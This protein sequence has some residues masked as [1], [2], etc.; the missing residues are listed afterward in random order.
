LRPVAE[1][2]GAN[3][4]VSRFVYGSRANVPDYMVKG[5][6][7]YRIVTDQLGSPRLVVDVVTGAIAQRIDY[8]EFGQVTSDTNPGFQPFGFAGG[9]YD[10]D[11]KLVRFGTR[12][13][14]AETGRFA[15]KDPIR[16]AGGDGN[17]YVYVWNDPVNFI[18]PV[19][20]AGIRI[21][22]S[23]SAS[24]RAQVTRAIQRIIQTTRG[25]Q[26]FQQANQSPDTITIEKGRARYD[27]NTHTVYVD[28]CDIP[29]ITTSSGSTPGSLERTI[30]HE[31]GHSLGTRD[32]GPGDMNN[33]NLN[34]NP[35]ATELGQP[36]RTDY[37][38][39][40]IDLSGVAPAP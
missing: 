25:R 27:R 19:G 17:A 9:I 38:R 10:P 21:G 8:D 30:A 6:V 23:F 32:D 36:A 29:N 35:V 11:T 14:D 22:N 39:M 33:V 1:L 13:Y 4:V 28:P 7:T 31:V 18:D 24:G 3:A 12:D 34:E 15:T 37:F 2:D 5:G 20:L 40:E 16:F 26:I